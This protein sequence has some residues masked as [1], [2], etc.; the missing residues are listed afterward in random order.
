MTHKELH[1]SYLLLLRTQ[2]HIKGVN[3]TARVIGCSPAYVSRIASGKQAV[4]LKTM[5]K[6]IEKIK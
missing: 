5:E 1:D 3:A 4:S 6:I 2:I